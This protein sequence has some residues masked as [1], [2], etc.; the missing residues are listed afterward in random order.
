V[1][2]WP[3]SV[4]AD[5][6]RP[7]PGVVGVANAL[8]TATLHEA[9]GR[10]GALPSAIKPVA[11]GM[12]LCG[13]AVT[14]SCPPGNNLRIHHAIYVAQPG[15]VLVVAVGDGAEYGYWGEI[16]T[17]AA[18]ARH[19]GGLVIDGGVRDSARL[20][21]LGF[22]VFSRGVCIRG[23]DKDPAAGS[24]NHGVQLGD[25]I[26]EPGDLVVGDVDGGVVIARDRVADVVDAS[27]RRD[28]DEANQMQRLRD[29]ERTIDILAWPISELG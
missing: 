25:V 26:V 6:Q 2:E 20:T 24:I 10:H 7:D 3:A 13:P 21:A 29:G 12:Q 1:A 14:V 16:M 22:P 23:T 5:I 8:S 27:I 4:R 11:P 17:V 19:L 15:D 18:Q 28:A 9:S